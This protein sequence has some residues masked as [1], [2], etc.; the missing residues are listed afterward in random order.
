MVGPVL[1]M[2]T[3]DDLKDLVC[4]IAKTGT[5]RLMI[6]R[7]RYRT[8]REEKMAKTPLME[9]E[10]YHGR[11]QG[12]IADRDRVQAMERT[13]E[14]ACSELSLRFEQAFN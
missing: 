9:V 2:L 12:A 4:A 10:P 5:K 1:P 8:G 13:I 7:M 3:D 6:D 14:N 11:Y